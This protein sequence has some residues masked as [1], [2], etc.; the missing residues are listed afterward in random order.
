MSNGQ[1]Q[2]N[3]HPLSLTDMEANYHRFLVES[4]ASGM[5]WV[6]EQDGGFAICPSE[7]SDDVDV[8]PFWSNKDF[9]QV[10]C[11]DEWKSYE[12]IALDINEFLEDWIDGMHEDLILVG[13]NWN[14]NF[15][16]IEIEPLDLAEDFDDL[17]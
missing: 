15:E 2:P 12:P 13:I 16:G 14:K 9:A 17:D 8:M 11:I 3:N 7:Q 1:E 5:V 10:H 4:L 6:L